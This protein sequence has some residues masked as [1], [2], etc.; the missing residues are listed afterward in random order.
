MQK[1]LFQNIF[2]ARSW[3]FWKYHIKGTAKTTPKIEKIC[4]LCVYKEYMLRLQ[5]NANGS[6]LQKCI[7]F[8]EQRLNFSHLEGS[9]IP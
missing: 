2:T 1:K 9:I 4:I 5:S 8:V 6:F 3:S 7:N